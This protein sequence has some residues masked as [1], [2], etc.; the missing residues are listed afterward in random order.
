MKKKKLLNIFLLCVVIAMSVC[1][2]AACASKPDSVTVEQII[3]ANDRQKVIEEYGN[4]HVTLTADEVMYG[5]NLKTICF[6]SNEYGLIMDYED[7]ESE[8]KYNHCTCINGV[9]Y[10]ACKDGDEE[11]YYASIFT[12]DYTAFISEIRNINTQANVGTPEIK[13]GK[14]VLVTTETYD[15]T[16]FSLTYENTYYCNRETLLMKK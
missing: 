15:Y 9:R 11:Q 8:D 13:D 1:G 7:A 14:V 5:S 12:G 4:L 3:E 16:D 10:V 6:T 2:I